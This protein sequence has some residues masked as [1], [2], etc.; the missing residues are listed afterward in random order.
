MS[1]TTDSELE[2]VHWEVIHQSIHN[3][4]KK[5]EESPHFFYKESDAKCY[6]YHLLISKEY[7]TKHHKTKDGKYTC[8][9]HTEYLSNGGL[10]L[11]L[12]ILEPHGFGQRRFRRQRIACSI[13]LKFWDSANYEAKDERRIRETIIEKGTTSFIIYLARGGNWEDFKNKLKQFKPKHEEIYIESKR[14][15][16]LVTR[17]NP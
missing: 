13:E 4:I 12:V 1:K 6:L 16:A 5:F 2:K 7:F 14:A 3:L 10:P 11:D 9:V 15:M 8:I 17:T